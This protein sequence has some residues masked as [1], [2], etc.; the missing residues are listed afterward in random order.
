[1]MRIKYSNYKIKKYIYCKHYSN[2]ENKIFIKSQ[3]IR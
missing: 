3:K 2:D 1:M